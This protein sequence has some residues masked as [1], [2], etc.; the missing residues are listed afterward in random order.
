MEES[1]RSG[2]PGHPGLII[3]V[4][5]LAVLALGVG[6]VAGFLMGRGGGGAVGEAAPARAGA[7]P[8]AGAPGTAAPAGAVLPAGHTAGPDGI[9]RCVYDLADKDRHVL[10]GMTCVCDEPNCNRTPLLMCHCDRAH[11]M[12]A[13]TKQLIVEGMKPEQIGA[14]LEK[15]FGPGVLPGT[16]PNRPAR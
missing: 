2:G 14:E 8:P 9:V 6:F 7:V 13:L 10:D 15:K 4:A 5:A 11:Q 3:G 1:G 16:T 12:K